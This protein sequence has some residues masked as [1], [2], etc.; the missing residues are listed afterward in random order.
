[1]AREDYMI[2]DVNISTLARQ[3]KQKYGELNLYKHSLLLDKYLIDYKVVTQGIKFT[4]ENIKYTYWSKKNRVYN[5]VVNTNLT[6]NKF[7]KENSNLFILRKENKIKENK[8]IGYSI[9]DFLQFGKYKNKKTI[10]KV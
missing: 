4:I 5:G 3:S 6:L 2:G 10:Y 8:I 9:D 1:M 7:I